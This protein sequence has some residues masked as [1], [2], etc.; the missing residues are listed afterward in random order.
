MTI[1]NMFARILFAGLLTFLVSSVAFAEDEVFPVL[2]AGKTTYT[3][4]AV[5]NKTRSDIFI[6]HSQGMANLKV[7]DLDFQTQLRLG[8]QVAPPKPTAAE[9]IF[10]KP[11]LDKIEA[12]IQADPRVQELEAR[13]AGQIGEVI[14]RIDQRV[15]YGFT[16]VCILAYLWFAFLCRCV[17]VKVA[18]P[19]HDLIPLIWVPLLQQLPLLKAAGMSPWWFLT[20]LVPFAPLI[21]YIVWSFKITKARQKPAA[22][23]VLLLLPVLNFFALVFLALSRGA[24]DDNAAGNI[25]SLQQAPRREAA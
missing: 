5:L 7:K 9:K 8:Y 18:A 3:N 21:I 13:F 24:G 14:D 20:N 22:V 11:D 17:C 1:A 25:I 19:P 23:A 15:I 12:N 10:K 4:A 2:T 6:K 16:A